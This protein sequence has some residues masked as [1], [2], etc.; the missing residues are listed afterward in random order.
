[1]TDAL[2]YWR[3]AKAE[4]HRQLGHMPLSA[5]P[6]AY[7][8]TL[9]VILDTGDKST[10]FM[11]PRGGRILDSSWHGLPT[12]FRLPYPEV[13]L[14]MVAEDGKSPYV[15]LAKE[16][17]G[18]PHGYNILVW[19]MGQ[20]FG[21]WV[22][23]PMVLNVV[24]SGNRDTALIAAMCLAEQQKAVGAIDRTPWGAQ[25]L[26]STNTA[27]FTPAEVVLNLITALSCRNIHTETCVKPVHKKRQIK[28]GAIPFDEY[29]ILT[30]EVPQE[31][32]TPGD[33]THEG[34]S[35]REHLRRGH[36][37]RLPDHNIWINATIVNP[38]AAGK[39]HKSYRVF[40]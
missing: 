37:R 32:A 20:I 4:I 33:G 12:D 8:K 40:A 17:E 16:V 26:D 23:V 10:K 13:L 39:L 24:R 11:L 22:L 18:G 9:S 3:K 29:K 36:I 5:V 7:E 21:T 25:Q 1:M 28:W 19:S 2:N 14:E 27:N 35:P 31:Q 15:I 30:V 38:G 34:R 6:S